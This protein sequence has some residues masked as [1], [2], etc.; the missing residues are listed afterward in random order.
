MPDDSQAASLILF[1]ESDFFLNRD[2]YLN[3]S[4]IDWLRLIERNQFAC[5]AENT[6]HTSKS[7]L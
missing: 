6:R 3:T 4:R 2:E 5:N 1:L 7:H